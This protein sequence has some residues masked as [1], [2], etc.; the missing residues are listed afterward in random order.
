[1]AVHDLPHK[2]RQALAREHVGFIFQH[3]HLIGEF[4]AL[5]NI[6]IAGSISGKAGR[7]RAKELLELVGLSDRATHYPKQLSGGEQQRVA[8]A[9]ALMADPA[10]ILC[11]EPTGNLDP[12]TG[13]TVMEV[14]WKVVEK[15]QAAMI[16]V[17]HD[18]KVAEKAG[19][20][21]RLKEGSLHGV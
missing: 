1:N 12:Q 18:E 15:E 20:V 13:A 3:Y 17:T 9:R 10:I 14:L 5:E 11:D 21:M 2:K 8:I 16:L 7:E 19:R 4:N 6:A